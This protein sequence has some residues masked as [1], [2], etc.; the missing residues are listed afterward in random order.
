MHIP[1]YRY[2]VNARHDTESSHNASNISTFVED[3][4]SELKDNTDECTRKTDQVTIFISNKQDLIDE[5]V[6]L[7]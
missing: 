7:S 6:G 1:T 3:T 2:V 5:H 4:Q